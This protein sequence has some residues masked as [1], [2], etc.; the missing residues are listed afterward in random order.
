MTC[1]KRIEAVTSVAIEIVTE[2]T[3]LTSTLSAAA[4]TG[5]LSGSSISK[6]TVTVLGSNAPCQRL[7]RKGL[8][9]VRAIRG[10]IRGE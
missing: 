3:D 7:G 9:G 6:R 10:A 2:W 8:T 4:L 5:R 1:V